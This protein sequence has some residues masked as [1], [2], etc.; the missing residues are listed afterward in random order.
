MKIYLACPYSHKS[1]GVR[2]SRF[3]AAN[4]AAA[5]LMK[6]GHQVF[7]PISHSV[8]VAETGIVPNM[9][10]N[11]W[12]KQDFAF[13]EWADVMYVLKIP[14]WETSTGVTDEIAEAKR[15]NLPVIKVSMEDLKRRAYNYNELKQQRATDN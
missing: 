14:G 1:L 13:L 8:P 11:F 3:I 12:R 10:W 15:I 7:S 5:Y 2:N 6:A 4:K 9:S